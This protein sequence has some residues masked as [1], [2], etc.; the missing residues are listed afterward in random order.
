VFLPRADVAVVDSA[1]VRDYLLSNSHPVGR[2]KAAIF[3]ALGYSQEEWRRLQHDLLAFVRLDS[4]VLGQSSPYGVKFEI[5][6][7]LTGPNGRSARIITIWLAKGDDRVPRL[8][9]AFPG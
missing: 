1:K 9:T 3:N 6:G 4:C 8:V 2:F 7:T 5:R